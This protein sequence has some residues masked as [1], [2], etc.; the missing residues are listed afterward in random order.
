MKVQVYKIS[1]FALTPLLAYAESF[2]RIVDAKLPQEHR[3]LADD[4]FDAYTDLN[5]QRSM[6]EVKFEEVIAEA[7]RMTDRAWHGLNHQAQASALWFDDDISE[8]GKKVVEVIDGIGNPT[9]LSYETGYDLLNQLL[10]ALHE[11]PQDVIDKSACGMWITE[12]E[13]RWNVFLE[14]R[15]EK[16]VAKSLTEA[17][18]VKKLRAAF[19]ASYRSFVEQ[20]NALLVLH[21]TDALEDLAKALNELIDSHRAL[22]KAAATR[23][24]K[25]AE[26]DAA[27]KEEAAKNAA[28]GNADASAPTD[29]DI[30]EADSALEA[31]S[32][33]PAPDA[34]TPTK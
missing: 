23:K 22:Q 12:L 8:A 10:S 1:N 30:P 26:E 14:L 17:G 32:I 13:H 25:A 19:E 20:L 7:D 2:K 4:L 9:Y 15:K 34:D 27:K 18:A 5:S 33:Q 6:A 24:K 28:S 3:S 11:L 16:N 29:T 21:S 31:S